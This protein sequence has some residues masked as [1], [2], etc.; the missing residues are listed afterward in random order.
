MN[1]EYHLNRYS[2]TSFGIMEL[3]SLQGASG[4]AVVL[5]VSSIN[6]LRIASI[7]AIIS[8]VDLFKPLC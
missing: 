1:T 7:S 5:L 3:L 8:D 6:C 4:V 2:L